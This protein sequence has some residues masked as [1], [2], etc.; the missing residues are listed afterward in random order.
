MPQYTSI[1]HRNS[2]KDTS[3][4][5]YRV[6]SK[7]RLKI[8]IGIKARVQITISTLREQIKTFFVN[9]PGTRFA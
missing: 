7:R 4:F 5:K 3:T 6:S 1:K 8:S 9:G 2:V